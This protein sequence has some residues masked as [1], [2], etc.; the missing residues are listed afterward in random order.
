VAARSTGVGGAFEARLRIAASMGFDHFFNDL[1]ASLQ[2]F[3]IDL[4]LS[5]DNAVVIA[6]ACRQLPPAQMRRAML[7]GTFGAIA[8][9]I[10]LTSIASFLMSLPA[11]R[12][13]GGVALVWVAI[14]LVLDEEQDA[15][16]TPSGRGREPLG[17][18]SA[19]GTVIIADVVMSVDNVVA[20]AAAS[21]G[22]VIFLTLGLLLSVP[23]LM[24]GSLFVTTLLARYPLLIR[25]GGALLGWLAGDIAIADPMFAEG[26]RQQAPALTFLVPILAAIFVLAESRIIEGA[27]TTLTRPQRRASRLVAMPPEAARSEDAA[28]LAVMKGSGA[29]SKAGG[30]V[31]KPLWQFLS[32]TALAGIPLSVSLA[33]AR[34]VLPWL[35]GAALVGAGITFLKAN[36]MPPPGDLNRFVC[37]DQS[38]I[39]FRHGGDVVRMSS[40]SGTINGVMRFDRI[41]WGNYDAARKV[42][43]FLP[44]TEI[45]YDDAKT[46]RINGGRFVDISCYAQ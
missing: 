15:D 14:K 34:L 10:L 36:W 30:S 9:R 45:R 3:L 8:A 35:V 46:V 32:N 1:S 7:L 28:T 13:L 38:S 42:L 18:W 16:S 24:F 17:L 11:L 26:V 39:Y 23:L 27:R 29:E 41:D 21:Q 4:L 6:L 20:L 12:L 37:P 43:G 33:K 2:V 19:V 5:G 25:G 40:H 44:P 22:S 31:N